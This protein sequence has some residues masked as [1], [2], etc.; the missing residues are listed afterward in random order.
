VGS[1]SSISESW[2]GSIR[3]LDLS[4]FPPDA[5]P[6]AAKA[7]A[8]VVTLGAVP[9]VTN[10][11]IPVFTDDMAAAKAVAKAVSTKGGGLPGVEVRMATCLGFYE[12]EQQ[13]QWQH[14]TFHR[15][16]SESKCGAA[17]TCAMHCLALSLTVMFTASCGEL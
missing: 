13:Y 10:F 3:D 17:T 11:N 2:Q 14:A 16:I 6:Y 12:Y 9:W 8:G 7:A 15:S 4:G 5:G 1:S